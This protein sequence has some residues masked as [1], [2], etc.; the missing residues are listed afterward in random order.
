MG[1]EGQKAS[2]CR[3]SWPASRPALSSLGCGCGN[4]AAVFLSP[5]AASPAG[6]NCLQSLERAIS[7][8]DGMDRP[9]IRPDSPRFA[10][11]KR[12][13]HS[14]REQDFL[15]MHAA[16]I[17]EYGELCGQVL[18]NE[19]MEKGAGEDSRTGS[20]DWRR[21]RMNRIMG[22]RGCLSCSSSCP[23]W[24]FSIASPKLIFCVASQLDPSRGRR[25]HTRDPLVGDRICRL[26]AVLCRA[27]PKGQKKSPKPHCS[28]GLDWPIALA[29]VGPKAVC[30][31]ERA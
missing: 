11:R 16:C 5:L 15:R 14:E 4:I 3:G 10:T 6:A 26:F 25:P 7:P 22:C 1:K 9:Q 28:L 21:R 23:S 30:Y 12:Q 27:S 13:E 18:P 20:S 24:P 19:K 17:M 29:M 8:F 31:P 2:H